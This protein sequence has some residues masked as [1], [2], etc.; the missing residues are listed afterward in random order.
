MTH[1]KKQPWLT[2]CSGEH[3][4]RGL[5]RCRLQLEHVQQLAGVLVKHHHIVVLEVARRA[6]GRRSQAD[7]PELAR[8]LHGEEERPCNVMHNASECVALC[9]S[10][11]DALRC[12]QSYLFVQTN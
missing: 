12:Y 4:H 3:G 7:L 9:M 2:V 6:E 1:A 5:A 11:K 8:I 10:R